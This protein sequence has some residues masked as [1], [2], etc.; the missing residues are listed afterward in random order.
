MNT[1]L[2]STA[3]YDLKS[4]QDRLESLILRTPTGR[5]RE[6]L[7]EANIHTLEALK[8]LEQLQKL[9]QSQTP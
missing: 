3:L 9:P 4:A 6:L 2:F 7:T 5:T 1:T 8:R